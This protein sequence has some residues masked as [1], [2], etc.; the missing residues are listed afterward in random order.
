LIT[1]SFKTV[2]HSKE[3]TQKKFS[4]AND[5]KSAVGAVVLLLILLCSVG[6]RADKKDEDQDGN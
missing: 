3:K 6:R 5:G 4:D 1:K 2:K